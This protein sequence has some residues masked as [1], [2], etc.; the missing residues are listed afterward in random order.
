MKQKILMLLAVMLLG[1]VSAFAQS[2][3]TV[4]LKGDV[5][6]DG[7]VDVADITAVI[8]IMKKG[9][10]GY[11]YFGTIQP[12]AENYQSLPGVLGN[13]TSIVEVS[14]ATVSVAVG[15]TLYML[16]PASWMDGK[17]VTMEDE[18]GNSFIFQKRLTL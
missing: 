7:R 3:D 1:S 6:G 16:C 2:G 12:T 17:N 5:N 10:A 13:Y 9:E 14:G 8:Q 15:E 4:K 11:F 18:N